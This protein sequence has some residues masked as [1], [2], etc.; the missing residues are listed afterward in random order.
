MAD[1]LQ[2]IAIHEVGH[3]VAAVTYGVSIV[4]VS[5]NRDLPHLHRGRY[6]APAN[7]ANWQP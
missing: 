7:I 2:R 1:Q 5:I 6:R 4:S 3:C